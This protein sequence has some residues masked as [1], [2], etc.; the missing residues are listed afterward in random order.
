MNS[1]FLDLFIDIGELVEFSLVDFEPGFNG[2]GLPQDLKLV[3]GVV[4][5][6]T[7]GLFRINVIDHHQDSDLLFNLVNA[8]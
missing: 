4:L 1:D 8:G 7:N 6:S 5:N 2:P 3:L